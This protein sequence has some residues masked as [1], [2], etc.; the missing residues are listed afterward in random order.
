ML[1]AGLAGDEESCDSVAGWRAGSTERR[2]EPLH[3][4][5]PAAPASTKRI[6]SDIFAAMNL[7]M[8]EEH[9]TEEK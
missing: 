9:S 2:V 1:R 8:V 5:W 7:R 6:R 3:G 4:L